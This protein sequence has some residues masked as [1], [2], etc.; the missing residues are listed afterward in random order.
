M[1]N[2]FVILFLGGWTPPFEHYLFE[3]YAQ[4]FYSLKIMVVCYYFIALRAKVPRYRYDELM[5][6]GWEKYMPILL[7]YLLVLSTSFLVFYAD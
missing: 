3:Q 2:I 4:I 1:S 5:D 6:I 7:G